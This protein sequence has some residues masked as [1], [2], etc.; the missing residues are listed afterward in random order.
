MAG[1]DLNADILEAAYSQGIF[2]WP[3]ENFPL[4]WFSP[5][6]RGVLFF[7]K[8]KIPDS[9]RRKIKN[10][11]FEMKINQNFAQV[12]RE[13]AQV[14]R[15]GETGTWITPEMEEAYLE[16]N[17]RGEAI[18]FESY[19]DGKLVGALYGVLVAGVF[20]GE[21]MFFKESEASKVALVHTVKYLQNLGHTWMDI[22]MVTPVL[23]RFGGE[24]IPRRDFLKMIEEQHTK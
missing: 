6:Q 13:C 5:P 21:S 1:G 11:V 16:L 22:Q 23:E 12:M 7:D 2:P 8:F 18:S 10:Q 24:Y 9:T 17:R 3:H 20:S 14:P 4:L 15:N 19:K